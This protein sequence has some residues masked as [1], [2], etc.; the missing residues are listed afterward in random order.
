MHG[1]MSQDRQVI[2]VSFAHLQVNASSWVQQL[3]E[4]IP[5]RVPGGI[6]AGEQDPLSCKIGVLRKENPASVGHTP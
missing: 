3:R 1:R 4:D 6:L 2:L 5:L